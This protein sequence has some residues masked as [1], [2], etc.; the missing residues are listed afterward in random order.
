MA[1]DQEPMT[2]DEL[3]EFKQAMDEQAE[4]LREDLAEDLGGEPEDYRRH[5]VADGGE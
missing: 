2:D 1:R 5:P 4:Q 3:A